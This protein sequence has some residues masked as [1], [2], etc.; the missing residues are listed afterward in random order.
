MASG[1][2]LWGLENKNLRLFSQ[3]QKEYDICLIDALQYVTS[4]S[5]QKLDEIF[6]KYLND[7]CDWSFINNYSSNN[8][9]VLFNILQK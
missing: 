6:E 9:S 2:S 7:E 1:R 4:K 3:A 8:M 5:L